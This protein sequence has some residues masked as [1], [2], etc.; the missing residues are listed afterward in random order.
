[1][2]DWDKASRDLNRMLIGVAFLAGALLFWVGVQISR[3]DDAAKKPP[4]VHSLPVPAPL[5]D[6]YTAS[7]AAEAAALEALQQTPQYKDYIIA[8]QQREGIETRTVGEVGCR[9][10]LGKFVFD[11]EKKTAR[12]DCS[13][14]SKE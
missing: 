7:Q 6:Q 3:A 5:L 4:A 9:P 12:V 8:R 13:E 10:S 11:K 1:M 14:A 2:L